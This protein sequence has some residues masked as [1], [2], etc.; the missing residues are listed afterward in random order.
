MCSVYFLHGLDSSGRGTK[1]TFF[2][3]SFPHVHCPDFS[4]SLNRRL[5]ALRKICAGKSDLILIG[6]SYGGLMAT[7]FTIESPE[8][9]RQLILLAPALNYESFSPP[10][11]GKLDVP[12]HLIMG[13]Y[14]TVT[15]P[16]QVIP[17]AEKT[18]NNLEIH[19]EEDD[20]ML[21]SSFARLNWREWCRDMPSQKISAESGEQK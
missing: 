6:S 18:F 10:S 3:T 21:H 12:V 7:C 4:G 14:D 2:T 20:H 13:R 19:L 11:T 15:P 9:V 8:R 1:G 17:L 5:E 16:D